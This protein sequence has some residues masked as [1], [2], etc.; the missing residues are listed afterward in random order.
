MVRPRTLAPLSFGAALLACA[1]VQAAA[2]PT[3]AACG[4]FNVRQ[5]APELRP[6]LTR[7]KVLIVHDAARGRQHFIREV[8]FRKADQVFGFVVPTPTLPEVAKLAK[9][10]FTRLR[11]SFPFEPVGVGKGI[12]RGAGAGYGGRGTGGGVEVLAVEKVGSFTAFTLAATD[13]TALATWLKDNEL[14][15]TPETDLW[16]EHYVR[17]GFYYVAMR[18]DPPADAR[19]RRRAPIA[20]ETVR[21]SFDTPIAYYPYFEPE[22]QHDPKTPR[23]LEVWYVGA[24]PVVPVARLGE[25]TGSNTRWVRPLKPGRSHRNARR[26]LTAALYEEL[27]A[28]LPEG[29]L[30]VQTFQ[31]QKRRRT[32]YQDILFAAAAAKPTTP[33][34]QAALEPLLAVLDPGLAAEVR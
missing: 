29:P 15:S 22:P 7:E 9:N 31:D 30:V 2:P 10:P 19:S 27:D 6:S 4:V 25:T 11:D 20:A 8:A 33:E 32:G 24:D 26:Q 28:L 13:A 23:L 3:A 34:Q 14:T 5:L 17:M 21:I 12:G 18:Y 16:L 1:L